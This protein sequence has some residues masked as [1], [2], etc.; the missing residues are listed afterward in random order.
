MLCSDQIGPKFLEAC[1]RAGVSVPD[2]LAVIGVDNDEPLC[3]VCN[4]PLSS[5][6]PNHE[7]VGYEAARVLEQLMQGARQPK[8]AIWIQPS[9]IQ[10]RLSTQVLA[11]EDHLLANALSLIREHACSGLRANELARHVGVSRSVLQRRFRAL[12]KRTIHD[13]IMAV[14]LRQACA[15][16]ANTDLPLAEIAEKS[17]FKHQE[18]MGV[19]FKKHFHLTPAQHR[20]RVTPHRRYPTRCPA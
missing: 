13:E 4:P 3:E 11:V 8:R 15:L 1:R 18:Y 10:A 12:L 17:G 2:E 6:R 5:V 19:V 14:R 16:I 20:Q 7:L 9:G